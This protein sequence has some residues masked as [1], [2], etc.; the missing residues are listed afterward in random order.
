MML[1]PVIMCCGS[2]V[3][4][5]GVGLF[6]LLALATR[7]CV[8][9]RLQNDYII[10]THGPLQPKSNKAQVWCQMYIHLGHLF[11]LCKTHES[12]YVLHQASWTD[13]Q[14]RMD[15]IIKNC[16]SYHSPNLVRKQE[17]PINRHPTQKYPSIK[18]V[19]SPIIQM[20]SPISHSFK[21]WTGTGTWNSALRGGLHHRP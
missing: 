6:K 5:F 19:T 1:F 2:A 7:K 18:W 11:V 8:S 4:P 10:V 16:M 15:C 14:L 3:S 21:K 12:C 17:I 13:R 20:M 9:I